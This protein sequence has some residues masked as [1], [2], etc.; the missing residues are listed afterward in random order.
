MAATAT[1]ASATA[2]R[3]LREMNKRL[4]VTFMKREFP[5]R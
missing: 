4:A 5:P 2:P 3:R 1:A